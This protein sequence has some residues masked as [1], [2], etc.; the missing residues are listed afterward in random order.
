M[1]IN[2]RGRIIVLEGLDKSGKTTLA[3][4]IL[5]RFGT[6]SYFY[7]KGICSNTWIGHLSAHHPS[8]RLF[9]LE[10]IYIGWKNYLKTLCGISVI[11]DRCIVSAMCHLPLAGKLYNILILRLAAA[12][13]PKPDI[14]VFC[15]VDKNKR[16]NRLKN[17]ADNI[18]H[19]WLVEHPDYINRRE[20]AYRNYYNQFNKTKM[21]VDTTDYSIAEA[22]TQIINT[23]N[24]TNNYDTSLQPEFY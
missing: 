5:N 4:A 10:S 6:Q 11:Q 14:L 24:T 3:K 7:Q 1:K 18:H 21:I 2:P 9:A 20:E 19:R 17:D 22:T 16:I 13:I 15:T 23:I 12:I 8:T